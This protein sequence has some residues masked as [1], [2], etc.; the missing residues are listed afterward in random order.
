MV[1]DVFHVVNDLRMVN[2]VRGSPHYVRHWKA[3]VA[4]ACSVVAMHLR[5][6]LVHESTIVGWLE[7]GR[8]REERGRGGG[9]INVVGK[10]G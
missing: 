9:Y 2:I 8:E 6:P 10:G 3:P 4:W 5:C 7:R 1:G